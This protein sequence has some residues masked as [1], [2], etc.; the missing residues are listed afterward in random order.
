[1]RP[2]LTSVAF[3][4][5]A[6]VLA[7][8]AS[9]TG[10]VAAGSACDPLGK[11]VGETVVFCGPASARLSVFPGAVFKNGSCLT[12]RVNGVPH[13]TLSL[14]A[15]TQNA[16]TNNGEPYFGLTVTGQFSGPTGGGVIAYW[17][18]K[19]WGGPGVSFRG[20]ARAGTFTATGINGSRGQATG[21]Y[22][23]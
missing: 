1:V 3:L 7:G 18:G 17:K 16:R 21:R 8:V 5:V 12:R 23:C 9:S 20:N 13:F 6:V 15:R 11:L 10:A 22:R 2:V 14:G 4:F 19:R